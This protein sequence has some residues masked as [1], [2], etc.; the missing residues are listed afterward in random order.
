MHAYVWLYF[1]DSCNE[2]C[3]GSRTKA[4]QS[5]G[6]FMSWPLMSKLLHHCLSPW[7]PQESWNNLVRQQQK[8]HKSKE[9]ECVSV[10]VSVGGGKKCV[11][12]AVLQQ[13]SC[14]PIC[15]PLTGVLFSW[16]EQRAQTEAGGL[17]S[18]TPTNTHSHRWDAWSC[19]IHSDLCHRLPDRVFEESA[20]IWQWHS[21]CKSPTKVQESPIC[22]WSW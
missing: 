16:P 3:L 5:E 13:C 9:R 11:W 20:E 10:C 19:S 6:L 18:F 8:R 4:P 2:R 1:R 15:P 12:L 7:M 21:K 14:H 17:N 22:G